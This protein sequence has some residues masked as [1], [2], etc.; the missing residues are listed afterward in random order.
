VLF[1][2]AASRT[3]FLSSACGNAAEIAEWTECGKILSANTAAAMAKGIE[4][5]LADKQQLEAMAEAGVR[6]WAKRFTWQSIAAQYE[7]LYEQVLTA[8]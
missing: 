3:P 8:R 1:E 7:Q 5:M 2:A 4:E 6:S